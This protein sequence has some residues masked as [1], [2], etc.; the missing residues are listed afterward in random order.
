MSIW[1]PYICWA[2]EYL[3]STVNPIWAVISGITVYDALYYISSVQLLRVRE[4][5][6]YLAA[7][8]SFIADR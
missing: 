1:D 3:I 6:A 5:L 7:A 8:S 4:L 2:V